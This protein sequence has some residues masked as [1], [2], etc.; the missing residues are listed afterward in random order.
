MLLLARCALQPEFWPTGLGGWDEKGNWKA[1]FGPYSQWFDRA[2]RTLNPCGTAAFLSGPGWGECPALC[3]Q[4][5]A[6]L[7]DSLVGSQ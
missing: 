3:Q 6:L 5:H 1:G 7:I 2:A 4:L